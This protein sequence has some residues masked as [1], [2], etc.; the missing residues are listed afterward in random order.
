M[1]PARE[2][3]TVTREKFSKSSSL[4]ARFSQGES[5]GKEIGHNSEVC[6]T[7]AAT[8]SVLLQNVHCQ[9]PGHQI[10]RQSSKPRDE[11]CGEIEPGEQDRY[12]VQLSSRET[13]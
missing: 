7:A 10:A 6:H 13:D 2:G 5:N 3:E 9:K 12:R 4:T 11:S 8:D 1:R